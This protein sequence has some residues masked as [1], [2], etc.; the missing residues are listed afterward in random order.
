ME[1]QMSEN[2]TRWARFSEDGI[3]RYKLGRVWDEQ[4]PMILWVM[5]NPSTADAKTNDPTIRRCAGFS[6]EWDYGGMMVGNLF[7]WRETNPKKL[8]PKKDLVGPYNNEA[9]QE[10]AKDASMT[11]VAWGNCNGSV[12]FRHC[13]A[14]RIE[15]VLERLRSGPPIRTLGLTVKEQ[16]KHPLRVRR[17]TPCQPWER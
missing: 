4:K 16:P 11:I 17:D 8:N 14:E 5:L 9:L 2:V 13:V 1:V 7:A 15:E 6:K 10:M 3:Y 12:D